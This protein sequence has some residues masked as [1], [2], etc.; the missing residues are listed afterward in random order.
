MAEW[1]RAMPVD[2]G[3]LADLERDANLVGLAH[4]F[5]DLP[6]PYDAVLTRWVLVLDD[7]EVVTEVV[8]GD[9]GLV[10][11]VAYDPESLRHLAVHPDAWGRGIAREAVARS[12][13]SRLWVLEQNHR[14]R[15]LYESLG[16]APTGVT[17]ECPRKPHPTE[18]E[19]R[20]LGSSV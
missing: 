6:F 19:Y 9:Q 15:G 20:H 16:W 5:G 14:A 3:P 10:A 17:R 1:R 8:A 4:V 12:G 13:A 7:P 2:A 11:Y 18:L